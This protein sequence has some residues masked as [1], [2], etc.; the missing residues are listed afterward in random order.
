[1]FA[2]ED[3]GQRASG[4]TPNSPRMPSGASGLGSNVSNW[5]GA[6][7]RKTRMQASARVRPVA[8]WL[9]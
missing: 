1:M 4:V 9:S 7:H 5:L 3:A 8:A 6:P 2:E